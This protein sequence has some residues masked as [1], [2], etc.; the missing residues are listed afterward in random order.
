[1][2]TDTARSRRHLRHRS[3]ADIATDYSKECAEFKPIS[4][5]FFHTRRSMP[6]ISLWE[7]IHCILRFVGFLSDSQEYPG[8]MQV[9]KYH[10]E[11]KSHLLLRYM[12]PDHPGKISYLQSGG[13]LFLVF[14]FLEREGG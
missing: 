3:D 8:K 10:Q 1:M 12:N 13:F 4:H 2:G 6:G 5:V 9:K 7:W 11:K 14:I